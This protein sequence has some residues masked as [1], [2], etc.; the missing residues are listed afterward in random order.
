VFGEALQALIP[1]GRIVMAALPA[2]VGFLP[3][4]GGAMF[5][6]PM[7]NEVGDRMRMAYRAGVALSFIEYE[8][9]EVT[10]LL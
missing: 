2:L 6:A 7:V 10:D 1:N 3:M 4:V 5:S 9:I 8:P